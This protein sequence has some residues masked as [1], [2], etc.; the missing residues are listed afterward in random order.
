[1]QQI[2]FKNFLF[3]IKNIDRLA[4]LP[5]YE[6]LNVIKT[7]QALRGYAMTYKVEMIEKKDPIVQLEAS[8][9]SITDLFNG[10]LNETKGFK[11]QITVRVL[12]KKYKHK[13]ELE[14]AL[15]YFVSFTKTVINHSFRLE[16]S[17]QEIL[18][19]IDVWITNG[20]GQNFESIESQYINI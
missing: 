2:I 6:Q 11:N 7:N 14:F 1:M 5:L 18:Y 16:N 3:I 19:M 17:F 8:K 20:F 4:E 10:L 13:G 15:I 12:L 9:S